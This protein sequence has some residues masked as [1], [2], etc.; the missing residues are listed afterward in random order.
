M[1]LSET[2]FKELS[3]LLVRAGLKMLGDKVK[4]FRLAAEV[5]AKLRVCAVG[6]LNNFDA[7]FASEGIAPSKQEWLVEQCL[8]EMKPLLRQPEKFFQASLTGQKLYD[9]L[10]GRDG[11]PAGVK[12]EKLE[13]LYQLL[14]PRVADPFC[15]Y[16]ALIPQLKATG[17]RE[18][19]R[20]FDDIQLR[21][22]QIQSEF[23]DFAQRGLKG[24]DAKFS[25]LHSLILNRVLGQLLVNGLHGERTYEVSLDDIFVLPA[26]TRVINN[27][28]QAIQTANESAEILF[29]KGRRFVV[30]GQPGGGKTTWTRWLQRLALKQK[31]P[32][33]AIH[34]RFR[35]YA[36]KELPELH[37]L[38]REAADVHLQKR[39]T[40]DVL[41]V[42]LDDG[43]I[44]FL[45][46]GF[47]EVAPPRRDT[48][49]AWTIGLANAATRSTIVMT[50]RPLSTAHLQGLP[51]TWQQWKLEP[52]DVPRV[53]K[54][55]SRW[56]ACC[57]FLREDQR[58]IDAA[59][60]A[61]SWKAD[62]SV[63]QLTGNPLM[64]ATL[65]TVH[66]RDNRQLPRGRSDLYERYL[67]GML[68]LW[69]ESIQVERPVKLS[70]RQ[71]RQILQRYARHFLTHEIESLGEEE[72][73]SRVGMVSLTANILRDLKIEAPKMHE[74]G[75]PRLVLEELRE[76][77]GM[78]DGPGTYSFV[79]KSVAEFLFAEIIV[80][81]H[82]RSSEQGASEKIDRHW[83]YVRRAPD[84][85]RG[86][87]YFWVGLAAIG[88]RQGFIEELIS[89]TD[90]L[91]RVL[92][93]GLLYDQIT[94]LEMDW[95]KAQFL[96][97]IGKEMKTPK[98]DFHSTWI[99]GMLPIEPSTE[100]N[101]PKYQ[102]VAPTSWDMVAAFNEI[103]DALGLSP[104]D[105][106]VVNSPWSVYAW[107]YLVTKAISEKEPHWWLSTKC[108]AHALPVNG[109]IFSLACAFVELRYESD[110]GQM[111]PALM[112][113]M[114]DR[115]PKLKA[116][117]P[118]V[119]V[120]VLADL[121]SESYSNY[122]NGYNVLETF[123]QILPWVR[124]FEP[125]AQYLKSSRDCFRGYE[126]AEKL[127]S[128]VFCLGHLTEASKDTNLGKLGCLGELSEYV[129]SLISKRAAIT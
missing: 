97:L 75:F 43:R 9:Q 40:D 116:C 27:E 20:R 68:G 56:Y 24:S 55:I 80:E 110:R 128:L 53:E 52:F 4:D 74:Q 50:S 105:L 86:V 7:F 5:E 6:A 103:S 44:I 126:Q 129:E 29:E 119:F 31:K 98:E 93:L 87:L 39:L 111:P 108:V 91:D 66:H 101:V 92:A 22:T 13:R 113:L 77:T 37:S 30:E 79:H 88:D 90:D 25:Q 64:L 107:R 122:T 72:A 104:E 10:Y 23:S 47:D 96:R 35:D 73:G 100:A 34:L 32:L 117:L 26:L 41:D 48:V 84:R 115:W 89:S 95:A 124:Q 94:E 36:Q 3:K 45:L 112:T 46:D 19:L 127:D 28:T 54:Y 82:L 57:P 14:F 17:D 61:S 123:H 85:W 1:A 18:I 102:S 15:A 81:G 76:R 38:V 60:L 71:K 78:L 121:L 42:W 12:D 59:A 118:I 8:L 69:E 99:I 58:N 62:K 2:I 70:P 16:L 83:L 65:L 49:R 125:N 21:L 106:D 120:G 109:E 33:L 63:S 11:A 114:L 51:N 67:D